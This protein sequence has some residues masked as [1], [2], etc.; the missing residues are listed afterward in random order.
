M[1]AEEAGNVRPE[2]QN[3][4]DSERMGLDGVREVTACQVGDG[5]PQA[6]ARAEREAEGVEGAEADHV[7]SGGIHRRHG[8]DP[9]AP[10]QRFERQPPPPPSQNPGDGPE[11]GSTGID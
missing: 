11:G 1:C 7:R 3:G 4:R 6:T 9:H 2:N 5:V 10:E 8:P